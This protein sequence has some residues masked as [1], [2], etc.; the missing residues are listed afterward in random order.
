[1]SPFNDFPESDDLSETLDTRVETD[2]KRL[3]KQEA[4][5]AA[6]VGF[7]ESCPKCRGRKAIYSNV[8][9]R[10]LG[11]CFK[12]KGRGTLT[13]K[14]SKE[15]RETVKESHATR[16]AKE[17][18]ERLA[19]FAEEHPSEAQWVR[20]NASSFDFAAR[21]QEAVVKWGHLTPGQLGGIQKCLAARARAQEAK[22]ERVTQAPTVNLDGL[23]A[24]FGNASEH[25]K[26]PKLR[27]PGFTISPAK[28]GSANP[29]AM[30]VKSDS[31]QYLG[32]ITPDSR[33]Q[34]VRECDKETESRVVAAIQDPKAA[35][36]SYGR[37]TGRCSCCGRDLTDPVSIANGI[38]PVCANRFGW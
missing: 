36:I 35:A 22:A 10:Y 3:A 1:M 30:Y 9:G 27:L 11:E 18:A 5:Q 16:K 8:S 7:V 17:F 26:S 20:E 28:A 21:M 4:A 31:G 38:G 24:A 23:K 6:N 2:P 25:L 13:F 37:E 34:C 12:C 29:G 19:V 14:T 33:F 32:K 15:T